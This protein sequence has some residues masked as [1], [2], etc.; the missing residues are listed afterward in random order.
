MVVENTKVEHDD[1]SIF[2]QIRKKKIISETL[3]RN[4]FHC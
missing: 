1:P 4:S 3:H 2:T